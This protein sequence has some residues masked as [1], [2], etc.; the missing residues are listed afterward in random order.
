[1]SLRF[2]KVGWRRRLLA[3]VV[4]GLWLTVV[5]AGLL[6]LAS[7]ENRPGPGAAA[8]PRWP[9][10]SRID[11]D[12]AGPTL[13]LFAHP[14]CD[15][16]RAS[17]A[18]LAEIM[19]RA[20]PVPRAYVVFVDPGGLPGGWETS[21]NLR[22]ASLIHGALTSI[23][24]NGLEARR[25]GAHT[26]GQVLLYAV[27]GRLAFSGGIT[28]ARGHEGD[29]VGRASVLALLSRAHADAAQ[30]PVFGCSLLGS[31]DTPVFKQ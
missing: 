13:L 3:P 31:T 22:A 21:E 24:R 25:F 17:L 18:E 27:D 11:R 16:T 10:Q 29:S 5:V 23:D 30:S 7:Y 26:S 9:V 14:L 2:D 1:M 19:A 20:S 15:C 8:P 12:P 4:G 6:W 28:R